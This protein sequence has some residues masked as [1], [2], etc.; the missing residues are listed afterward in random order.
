M[1]FGVFYTIYP[2]KIVGFLIY[3]VGVANI[4]IV[5]EYVQFS[6]LPLDITVMG[7]T[8]EYWNAQYGNLD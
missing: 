6:D 5:R 4:H 2:I 1:D 7:D 8:R 3:I